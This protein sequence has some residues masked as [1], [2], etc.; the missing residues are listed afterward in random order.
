MTVGAR[1]RSA[2]E[3]AGPAVDALLRAFTWGNRTVMLPLLSHRHLGAWMGSPVAGWFAVLTT[4]GRRSGLP[5]RTPLNYAIVGGCVYVLSGFGTRADWYRNLLADPRVTVALPG[6][7]LAATAAV[8]TDPVEADAA[9]LAVARNCGFALL[10]EGLNPLTVT[11]DEL[12]RQLAGRPVV[13]LTAAAPVEPGR[14]DPGSPW[15]LLPRAAGA[16]ALVGVAA[17]V[18]Q[19]GRVMARGSTHRS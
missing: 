4:T 1:V 8:V 9:M 14:H 11:A 10:F 5:R 2:E 16:L 13:R 15:W 12:R 19:S 17:A 6:R 18:G 7:E 3:P